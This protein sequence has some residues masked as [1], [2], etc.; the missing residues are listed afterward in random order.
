MGWPRCAWPNRAVI[1]DLMLPGVDDLTAAFE[2][3]AREYDESEKD[4]GEVGLG[5]WVRMGD[6]FLRGLPAHL[7]RQYLLN[8]SAGSISRP[9]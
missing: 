3:V 7:L 8:L 6:D 5:E 4:S 9:C 1:L 2:A